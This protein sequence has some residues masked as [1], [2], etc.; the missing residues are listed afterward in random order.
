M[1]KQANIGRA[2]L[3]ILHFVHDHHPVTVRQVADELG[4]AKGIVRTTVLNVM[5]RLV[6][7]GFLARK[8]SQGFYQYSPRATK[9]QL[10]RTL[11][12]DFVDKSL[13]GS[14]SP[15]MAYLAQDAQL[16]K[17]EVEQLR[18]IVK[19]LDSSPIQR[20]QSKKSQGEP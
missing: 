6:S 13:G 15:F 17:Q 18:A 5:N 11:V 8:K 12:N 10:L 9:A 1:A 14:V 7:K 19:T 3:E 16:S 20:E 4:A 2:E